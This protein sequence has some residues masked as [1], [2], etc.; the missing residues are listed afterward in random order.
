MAQRAVGVVEAQGGQ[1][2]VDAA[3]V[4]PA[5]EPVHVLEQLGLAADQPVQFVAVGGF[6]GDGGVNGGQLGLDGLDLAEQPVQDLGDG[7]LAIQLGE[8]GEVPHLG[9]QLHADRAG[10]RGDLVEDQLQDGGLAGSVLADQAHPVARFQP[11]ER[12]AE[13]LGVLE[14]DADVVQPDQAHCCAD[15]CARFR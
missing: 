8:L 2:R 12:L 10:V 7:R 15:G 11:E 3:R 1:D 6:R 9:S 13:D 4:V 14:A 5:V